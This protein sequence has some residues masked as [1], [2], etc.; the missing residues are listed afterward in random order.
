MKKKYSGN[1]LLAP[2]LFLS[3]TVLNKILIQ[4]NLIHWHYMLFYKRMKF[5]VLNSLKF[6]KFNIRSV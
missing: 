1:V 3:P 4:A 2:K 5:A 6:K